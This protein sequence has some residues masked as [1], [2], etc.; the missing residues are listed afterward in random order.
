MTSSRAG[1]RELR[2]SGSR[3]RLQF[4]RFCAGRSIPRRGGGAP[5]RAVPAPAGAVP[6]AEVAL[7]P[8]PAWRLLGRPG[9][10]CPHLPCVRFAPLRCRDPSKGRGVQPPP[11]L[12]A[13][14]LRADR[15]P[16]R[17][18]PWRSSGVC[19]LETRP[20]A[21]FSPTKKPNATMPPHGS[22]RLSQ[23]SLGVLSR[24]SSVGLSA[25]PCPINGACFVLY[26]KTPKKIIWDVSNSF[27][28]MHVL[29][30][31]DYKRRILLPCNRIT[32]K[33]GLERTPGA[34]L[35]QPA[36]SGIS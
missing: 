19:A 15:P 8:S 6:E 26:Y 27:P 25:H 10:P 16:S 11:A 33:C 20:S 32:E 24:S 23:V 4:K 9:Y 3:W 28:T 2:P 14:G 34:H 5:G 22:K 21:A 35:V 18:R 36:P 13:C 31:L 30:C 1:G 17:G 29:G 12:G 7:S